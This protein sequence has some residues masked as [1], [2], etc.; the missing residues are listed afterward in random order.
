M[1]FHYSSLFIRSDVGLGKT[2]ILN[3]VAHEALSNDPLLK[4][5]YIKAEDF[6]NEYVISLK[7]KSYEKFKKKFRDLDLLLFDEAQFLDSKTSTQ[8][9]FCN[10]FDAIINSGGKVIISSNL[11]LEKFKKIEKKLKK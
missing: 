4:V 3:A 2:H 1:G 8:Q 7:N 11:A 5:K 6:L 10:V 9:E